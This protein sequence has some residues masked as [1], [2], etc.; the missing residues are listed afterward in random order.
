VSPSTGSLAFYAPDGAGFA[1]SELTR[2]PWDAES[3]HAGPPCALLGRALEREARRR[4]HHF[5]T[6]DAAIANGYADAIDRAYRGRILERRDH[7]SEY[8]PQRYFK[9][10]LRPARRGRTAAR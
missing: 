6:R 10:A 7:P 9:I 8:G 5:I 4:G 2:G 1:A 3:Q